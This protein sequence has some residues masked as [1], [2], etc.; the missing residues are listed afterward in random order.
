MEQCDAIR[1]EQE[2]RGTRVQA[3]LDT[4]AFL[5]Q[6]AAYEP[7]GQDRRALAQRAKQLLANYPSPMDFP[8]VD[9][10]PSWEGPKDLLA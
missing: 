6:L 5:E 9:P 2:Y 7:C 8:F 1:A 3:V 4:R 10:I